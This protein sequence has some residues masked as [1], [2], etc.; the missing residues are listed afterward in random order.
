MLCNSLASKLNTALGDVPDE[1]KEISETCPFNW[2][3]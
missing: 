3:E 1:N 2:T